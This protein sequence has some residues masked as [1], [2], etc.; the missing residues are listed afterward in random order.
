VIRPLCT[1]AFA[2]AFA[3]GASSASAQE[4]AKPAAAAPV[5]KLDEWPKLADADKERLLANVGQFRK[6]DP[7]LHEA[8]HKVLVSIGEPGMPL[9]F[10]QVSDQAQNVNPQLFAVFDE[11]CKPQHAALLARESKKN[12]VELRRYLMRRMCRFADADLLPVLKAAQQ[13]KDPETAFFGALGALAL[14]Q[15]EALPAA[16]AYCKTNWKDQGALVAEVLPAARCNEVGAWVFEA[17]AK[18]PVTEQM[19][20]LRFA[21]YVA[22]KE[23]TVIL[24]NYLQ[25]PDHTVKKEAVNAMRVLHGEPPIE[26]LDVF[27]SIEMAKEWLKKA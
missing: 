1:A 17:I 6:A 11:V 10:Q 23:Q 24:R 27:K 3:F 15:R 14:K 4:P 13:D 7:K 20:G 5:A 19:T 25:A 22:V 12:K 8:A 2:F 9:L 26:T 21:R 16:L 18:A